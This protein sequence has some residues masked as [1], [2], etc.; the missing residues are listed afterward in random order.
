MAKLNVETYRTQYLRT[1]EEHLMARKDQIEHFTSQNLHEALMTELN[2]AD[3]E[4]WLIEIPDDRDEA[5]CAA[6]ERII[7][8][9]KH[10]IDLGVGH[11]AVVERLE[12]EKSEFKP[13][14]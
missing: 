12:T 5:I 7:E 10:N 2:R 3:P 13:L 9:M 4:T 8:T 6:E 1:V 14:E 11:G